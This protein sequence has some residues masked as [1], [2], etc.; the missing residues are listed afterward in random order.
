M[1]TM[2]DEKIRVQSYSGYRTEES[3]R[4]FIFRNEE[5]EI[6]EIIDLWVEE[7]VRDGKR[8]RFFRVKGSDGFIHNI[9]M[10]D[11]TREWYLSNT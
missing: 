8:R 2:P 7:D 10:D 9:Y 5:I 1:S 3:P 6:T 11:K 4:A